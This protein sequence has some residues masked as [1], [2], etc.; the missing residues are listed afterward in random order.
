MK[1]LLGSRS[2]MEDMGLMLTLLLKMEEMLMLLI[3]LILFLKLAV[4]EVI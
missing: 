2:V 4:T 1:I 3:F